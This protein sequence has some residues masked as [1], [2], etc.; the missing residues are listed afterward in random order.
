[1]SLMAEGL[2]QV[3]ARSKMPVAKTPEA[4]QYK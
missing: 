3:E 1:M 4:Y 2:S